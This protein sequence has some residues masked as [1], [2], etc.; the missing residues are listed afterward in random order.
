VH[1]QETTDPLAAL[2]RG[3]PDVRA[4]LERSGVDPDEGQVPD[5]RIRH[6]L[7]GDRREG[8]VAIRPPQLLRTLLVDT[9]NRGHVERRRQV[10][11]DGV[12]ERLYALV[13]EG[14]S[15][16]HGNHRETDRRGANRLAQPIFGDIGAVQ[17]LLQKLLVVVGDCFE[18][19]LAIRLCRRGKVVRDLLFMEARAERLLVPDHG[20]HG[21]QI[22][23]PAEALFLADRDLHDQGNRSELLLDL[24]DHGIEVRADPI[25][26]VDECDSRNR[27][28]VR[29]AP[30]RFG[31][32]LDAA[33]RTEKSD[34]TVQNP[35]RSLD[36]DGKIYVTRRIDDVDT[37]TPPLAGGRG[38]CDRDAALLL[39]LHPVHRGVAIVDLTD[40][41]VDPR[42]VENALG[43]SGLAGIDV[44]HDADVSRSLE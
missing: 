2:L 6:D 42:V 19:P 10:V 28:L 23:H 14:G 18:Q 31:L 44:G 24:A 16:E 30:H 36:L 3:V 1:L 33:D 11:H 13:L 17:V 7:E 22:D 27:V 12:E 35:E 41:I 38:G 40:S 5:V 21:D 15:T 8:L 29:L 37:V 9:R 26:L 20:L 25:H 34:R 43:R 32:R 4:R 39:L